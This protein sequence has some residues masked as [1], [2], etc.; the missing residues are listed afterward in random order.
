MD[1]VWKDSNL[2]YTAFVWKAL[3]WNNFKHYQRVRLNEGCAR[4]HLLWIC[5]RTPWK[6]TLYSQPHFLSTQGPPSWLTSEALRDFLRPLKS[7]I[8]VNIKHH[9]LGNWN[10]A[11]G[12]DLSLQL[13]WVL[14]ESLICTTNNNSRWNNLF[15]PVLVTIQISGFTQADPKSPLSLQVSPSFPP[16]HTYTEKEVTEN[17]Q[18][19]GP[20]IICI[21]WV[22]ELWK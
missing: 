21:Q 15:H 13:Q 16:N 4:Y 10:V 5:T 12:T 8:L 17:F 20:F 14:K 1:R 9:I 7:Q 3:C 2:I 6:E 19:V 11:L 18:V 22:K